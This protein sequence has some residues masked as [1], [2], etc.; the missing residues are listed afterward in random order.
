[1]SRYDILIILRIFGDIARGHPLSK[2]AKFSEK[3]T[4]LTP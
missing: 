4:F 3:F 1:M 2:Y